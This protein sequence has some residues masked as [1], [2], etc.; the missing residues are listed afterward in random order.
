[1]ASTVERR[2]AASG[3]RVDGRRV[4]DHLLK[5]AEFGKNTQRG[6]GNH[7]LTRGLGLLTVVK[8]NRAPNVGLPTD[9]RAA[10]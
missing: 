2:T 3:P 6:V 4:N 5:L 10:A 7:E 8:A 1:M 9:G